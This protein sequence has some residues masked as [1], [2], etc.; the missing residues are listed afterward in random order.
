MY[1]S[2]GFFK[3]NDN[4]FHF[5]SSCYIVDVDRTYE[6]FSAIK[7]LRVGAEGDL[8]IGFL[9]LGQITNS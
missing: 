3:W 5:C 2:L 7:S 6:D 9:G 8:S 1:F 4:L